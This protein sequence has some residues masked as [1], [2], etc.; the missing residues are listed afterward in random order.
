M[1]PFTPHA[2]ILQGRG[3]GDCHQNMGAGVPAITDY[4]D[5]GI[6][7]FVTFNDADST[8]SYHQGVVPLPI[9]YET[10]F[11]M[12][13]ITYNGSPQDPVAPSKNWSPIGEDTPDGHQLFFATPLSKDQMDAL[14]MDTTL[15]SVEDNFSDIPTEFEL[16]Q[17]YPNPFN[18]ST[19]I[20]YTVPYNSFVE[21]S[22]YDMNGQLIETLVSGQQSYGT[23]TVSFK[24]ENL[25]SGI[26]FYQLTTPKSTISKKMMLMK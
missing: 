21:L 14:G 19:Q 24:A 26:Y 5:D 18:P 9:D 8:L 20:T 15:V 12:D 25:A 10:A 22:V 16:A 2:T 7:K 6:M 4:N 1:A 3:C 17:N 13:F 11:R 23:H